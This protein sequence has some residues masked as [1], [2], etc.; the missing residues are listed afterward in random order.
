MSSEG[1]EAMDITV[2]GENTGSVRRSALIEFVQWQRALFARSSLLVCHIGTTT[3]R[4][5]L[6]KDQHYNKQWFITFVNR[7]YVGFL[8]IAE[9]DLASES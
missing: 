2:S 8:S 3:K 7:F 9:F 1:L 4:N 5:F 6:K